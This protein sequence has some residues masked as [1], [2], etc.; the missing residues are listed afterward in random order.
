MLVQKDICVLPPGTQALAW[1]PISSEVPASDRLKS[2]KFTLHVGENITISLSKAE[3]LRI[4]VPKLEFGNEKR[5][6]CE[7]EIAVAIHFAF[8]VY[9]G[10]TG[11]PGL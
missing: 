6:E 4:C 8:D 2:A 3:A 5:A 7:F 11:S 10:T 1:A 9:M